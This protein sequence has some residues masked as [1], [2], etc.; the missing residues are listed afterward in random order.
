MHHPF[1]VFCG[2]LNAT[3]CT[4][5]CEQGA[6]ASVFGGEAALWSEFVDGANIES[7]VWPRLGAVAEVGIPHCTDSRLLSPNFLSHLAC[8]ASGD[9][10]SCTT[11]VQEH[12]GAPASHYG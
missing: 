8:V 9:V 5:K 2:L 11:L 6:G 4:H 12:V 1:C 3:L 10:V 7:R